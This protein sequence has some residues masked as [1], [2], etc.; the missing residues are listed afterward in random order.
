MSGYDSP[1]PQCLQPTNIYY[2]H[3]CYPA[4]WQDNFQNWTSGLSDLDKLI[5]ASQTSAAQDY[6]LIEWI[7]Y[8]NFHDIEYIAN[9]GFGS[10]YSAIWKD[11]PITRGEFEE[12]FFFWDDERSQ[13]HR[14][15]ECQVAIKK[16]INGTPVVDILSQVI[17]NR[18]MSY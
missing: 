13:W 3:K 2:C 6:Q 12:Y 16:I 1:C 14:S 11:G 15:P 8:S 17:I 5:Q 18:C 4:H 10:V 9:G 7:E